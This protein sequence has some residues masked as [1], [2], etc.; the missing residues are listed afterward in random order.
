MR[1][2]ILGCHS[3]YPGAN[4]ATAGYLLQTDEVNLLFDCGSGVISQ[5]L[6]YLPISE[7]DAV[8]LS[9]YHHDHVADIGVLQYGTMLHMRMNDRVKGSLPIYGPANPEEKGLK[10]TYETYTTFHEVNEESRITIGDCTVTFLQTQHD[11]TCYA[12]RIQQGEKTIVYGADSG[13]MTRWFPFVR[14]ADLFI[15]EGTFLEKYKPPTPT[16]HLSVREA[17]AVA[18]QIGC[19]MFVV[20]HLFP[21]YQDSD[22]RAEMEGYTRGEG[23]VAKIGLQLTL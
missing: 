22:V 17:A 1:L 9:H 6:N 16:G 14:A 8:F 15:G 12:M 11:I 19:S 13:P 18:E 20:T 2:T 3:P 7:L 5:L 4:G 10:L 21:A 23:Y